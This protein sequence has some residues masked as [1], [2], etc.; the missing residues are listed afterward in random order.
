[1]AF[2][3]FDFTLSNPLRP[4]MQGEKLVSDTSAFLYYTNKPNY[5]TKLFDYTFYRRWLRSYEDK[6]CYIQPYQKSDTLFIQWLSS[7]TT[8]AHFAARYLRKDGTWYDSKTITVVK[9]GTTYAGETLYYIIDPLYDLPE[10]VYFLQI[11][12]S[13][14]SLIYPVLFEV[15]ACS[16]NFITS[17]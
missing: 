3:L 10:G 17:F 13:Y 5:N 15:S 11:Y 16:N 4:I 2:K 1:M 14:S 6:K 7:D 9:H 8:L 12:C